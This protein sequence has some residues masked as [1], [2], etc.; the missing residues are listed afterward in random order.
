MSTEIRC[1]AAQ[2]APDALAAGVTADHGV[3]PTVDTIQAWLVTQLADRVGVAPEEIDSREPFA[4]YGVPSSE[5]VVLSGDLGDWLGRRLSPTLLWEFPTIEALAHHLAEGP[6]SVVND[7]LQ[8]AAANQQSITNEAIA[9]IGIGCRF[10]GAAGPAAFWQ[11]LCEGRDTITEIPAARWDLNALYDPDPDAPGTMSTRWGGFLEH[12]DQF[13]PHFFCISP[14]EAARMDPQQRLLL[15]VSWEALEHAGLAPDNVWGTQAGVFVGVSSSDYSLVQMRDPALVDAYTGTGNAHSIAANRL[16][17]LLDLHG[18]SL[19]V[20]TACSSSL[21]AVHLACQSLRQKEC[22][23]ALAG[24]VNLILTPQLTVAFSKAHM[25]AADGRCKTFDAAADGYVRGE[26]CGMVILKRLS[27]ALADGDTI[28]ALIRG[29][30]VNQDG[31]SNGLTAPNGQAQQAVIRQALHNAGVIADQIGYVETHGTG[32]P[33]GDPI[34]IEALTAVLGQNRTPDQRCVLGSVKSNIGHLEAAAGI[35]GLIK[36]ILALQHGEIPAHLNFKQLNPRISLDSGHFSIP[37]EGQPWPTEY[38]QRCAGVSSFGFGGTN[39]HVIVSEAPRTTTITP[40]I[41][42]PLHLLTLSAQSETALRTM[43]YRYSEFM[44][45]HPDVPLADVC[46]T[47]NSGRLHFIHRLAATAPSSARLRDQLVAFAAGNEADRLISGQL[48]QK[49]PPKVAF[50]F[51]GQ[52]AQYVGMGRQLYDTQPTFRSALD[53]CAE[54]L[55]PHLGLDLRDVL[56]PDDQDGGQSSVVGGQPLDQ[57]WLTQP[58]LFALEYALA[59]LWQ[60]WGITPAAVIGHSIGEYV[61]ACVAGV[62][63]LEDGLRLVAERGRLMQALP[64]DGE[65]VAVSASEAQVADAIRPYADRVSIAAINSPFDLVISGAREAIQA[66]VVELESDGIKTRGL[67]VSHAFHSP[68]MDPMLDAF[69]Q[70]TASVTY[71]SPRIP[72]ISNVTG[73]LMP[74]GLATQPGYWRRHVREAVR[75]ADGMEAL[76]EQGCEIFLELGPSATLLGMGQRCMPEGSGVWLPSLR[77]GQGD[78][79]QLLTSLAELYVRGVKVDWAAFDR[80]YARPRIALPTYPFERRRCWCDVPEEEGRW[81]RSDACAVNGE[82]LSAAYEDMAVIATAA[83]FGAGD[84]V[85]ADIALQEPLHFDSDESRIVQFILTPDHT[86]RV[87]FKAL[88]RRATA[89]ERQAAWTHHADGTLCQCDEETPTSTVRHS[90]EGLYELEWQLK[91]RILEEQPSQPHTI[92]L[93][94]HWLIFADDDQVGASLAE[95]IRALGETCTLVFPGET[96][97]VLGQGCYTIHPLRHE[98]YRRLLEELRAIDGLPCRGVIHLWGLDHSHQDAAQGSSSALLL[99]QAL[100]AVGWSQWP[101]LWFVTRGAQPA[102]PERA[103]LAVNQAPLWGLGRVLALEHPELWGGLVDLD[104]G[105]RENE[106]MRLLD[107]IRAPDGED[108]IAFR[109][110]QRYAVRLASMQALDIQPVAWRP[111]ATYMITGGLG[112]LGLKVA[113]RMVERGARHLVLLSRRVFPARST[114]ADSTH[115]SEQGH[116]IAAVQ[117]LEALGARVHVLQADVSDLGRMTAVF[118]ELQRTHPPLRGIVHAAG[119]AS[120]RPVQDIAP[121][122]LDAALRPKVL[123]AWVLHQ[124]TQDL[125][126]D[127]FVSF[128]SVASVLG[129]QSLAHYAAANHFLDALAHHRQAIGLPGL[130]INWGPWAEGGLTSLEDQAALARMGMLALRPERALDVLER[131]LSSGTSQAMVAQIDWDTFLPI[132]EARTRRPILEAVASHV[133][134][135]RIEAVTGKPDLIQ[136]LEEAPPNTRQHVLVAHIQGEV[137]RVLDLEP[138]SWIDPQQGFFDLG[139]DSLMAVELKRRLEKCLGLVLPRTAAF[140]FPTIET[141]ATYLLYD[142][143]HLEPSQTQATDADEQQAQRLDLLAEIKQL[144]DQNVEASLVAELERLNY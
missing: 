36:A 105:S 101:R 3:R 120:P 76:S 106:T 132:Y 55:K 68:L 2:V 93:P 87:H 5:A 15:E 71:D 72:L 65:M 82:V 78:W 83:A 53:Q 51:T 110:E 29:S 111:D 134:D 125:N 44:A 9:V 103:A 8:H 46:F 91:P 22:N 81:L 37:V 90:T 139:M 41:E 16:S 25:M 47:A 60:S 86:G 123:G 119:V 143:L 70:V 56:Y 121:G 14:R 31:L 12:V 40:H 49:Q 100:L 62:F 61:A 77:K 144:S 13:D 4:A 35:A 73:T 104:P 50:L 112:A 6:L 58:A 102:G 20:D 135:T 26:G 59:T 42:R 136:Q 24:G 54:L 97:S 116:Q 133:P 30:A 69:E 1:A 43:A 141:L 21:V 94:G 96:Y 23:L 109:G 122:L 138:A 48:Q 38:E 32:T 84:R 115:D 127:F 19:A 131:L 17:Y 64:C 10:P 89:E 11:L 66:V 95:H 39:A 98:D 18:P 124:L 99:V 28:L 79:P 142:M 140:D 114:W 113:R 34:E 80:D 108:Q 118:A 33:L 129:S 7:R 74:E 57:T 75:F 52:G 92:D 137:V 88:S 45:T 27:D 130:S 117:A 126:L 85:A 128:S 107:E 67:T 63:S